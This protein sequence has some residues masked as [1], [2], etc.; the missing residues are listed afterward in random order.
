MKVVQVPGPGKA[1]ET[2]ERAA[3]QPGRGQVRVAVKACGVCHSD[4]LVKEGHW[5]GLA[6]PRAPGHEVTGVVDAVGPDVEGWKAGDRVGIG[7]HG[8]HCFRCDRCR[9]GDFI[10]CA[11]QQITGIHHDGGYGEH[12]LAPAEGLARLPDG[13]GF[14]EAAPLLCAGVTVFNA[15]RNSS[16]RPGDTVAV[17]GIG[18]LGH[19]GLQVASKL[20]FR[21][22]A[23]SHGPDKEALARELGAHEYVDTRAGDPAKALQRLGGANLILATAPQA[24][25]IAAVV[26]GLATEGELLVVAAP[27]E[28][29]PVN[30]LALL[31]RR[32]RVQGWP[33]GTAPDS[34]DTLRFCARAGVRPRI[35][36]FP[37]ARAA[38][39]YARMVSGAA[40]FRVVI[41]VD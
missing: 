23:V 24:S 34:E 37:L 15:L 27:H 13:L 10:T 2:V 25:A 4:A 11:R 8:G 26:D 3:P 22:I 19:L 12:M 36:T 1:F 29:V 17:Q 14:A 41:T 7:W 9:R 31:S 32:R 5:P 30:V 28:P 40:R 18:G 35:E 20:G 33:S 21:T 6:F 38:D 39:A 16:A